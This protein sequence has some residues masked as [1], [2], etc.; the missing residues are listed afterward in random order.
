[1]G[2][3]KDERFGNNRGHKVIRIYDKGYLG[4]Q[5]NG[6]DWAISFFQRV[7][8]FYNGWKEAKPVPGLAWCS[9]L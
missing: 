9:S 4:F 1:M 3:R 8:L 2:F 5:E 6:V 7:L